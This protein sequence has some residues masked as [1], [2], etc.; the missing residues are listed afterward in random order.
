MTTD[1]EVLNMEEAA[2]FLGVTPYLI[3]EYARRWII[4]GKIIE[5]EWQFQKAD[6]A[7][8]HNRHFDD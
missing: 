7:W 1:Q 6:L 4:P 8:L 5:K 2:E 3:W